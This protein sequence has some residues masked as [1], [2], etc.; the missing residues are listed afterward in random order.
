V[1]SSFPSPSVSL[2]AELSCESGRPLREIG[3]ATAIKLPHHAPR[4]AGAAE[5]T[6]SA[7]NCFRHTRQSCS[8]Q[9]H[10]QRART[11]AS[12]ASH[13]TCGKWGLCRRESPA[14]QQPGLIQAWCGAERAVLE[15]ASWEQALG[16]GPLRW[17]KR[18]SLACNGLSHGCLN[19]GERDALAGSDDEDEQAIVSSSSSSGD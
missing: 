10:V 3:P 12:R 19:G 4:S 2:L 9:P 15:L 1:L 7:L 11:R 18:E 6:G 17:C 14:V 8:A 16:T 13:D 5:S